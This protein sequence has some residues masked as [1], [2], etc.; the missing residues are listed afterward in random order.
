MYWQKTRLDVVKKVIELKFL[1]RKY[2]N[3]CQTNKSTRPVLSV[4]LPMYKEIRFS[5]QEYE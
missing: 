1:V 4:S 2:E 5:C 3:I